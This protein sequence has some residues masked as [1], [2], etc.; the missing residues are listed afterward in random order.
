MMR[1]RNRLITGLLVLTLPVALA[2]PSWAADKTPGKGEALIQE[3]LIQVRTNQLLTEN[4]KL[5]LSAARTMATNEITMDRNQKNMG[6]GE[7]A[8]SLG[9]TVGALGGASGRGAGQGEAHAASANAGGTGGGG[10]GGG[11]GGGH[12]ADHGADHGGGGGNGGGKK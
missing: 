11:N 6:W 1:H 5:S 12:S 7:I 9:T 4:P 2:A 8:H 3:R 10:K